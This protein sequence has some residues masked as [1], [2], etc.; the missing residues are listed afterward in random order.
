VRLNSLSGGESAAGTLSLEQISI[1]NPLFS[2]IIMARHLFPLCD[3]FYA[4]SR[5]IARGSSVG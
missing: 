3:Q 2:E 1:M 4:A 5:N